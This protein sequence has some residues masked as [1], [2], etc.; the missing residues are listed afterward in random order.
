MNKKK[1]AGLIAAGAVVVA[2]FFVATQNEPLPVITRTRPPPSPSASVPPSG[3]GGT[4][5]YIGCSNTKI[6]VEGYHEVGGTKFWPSLN[7][8]G[9]TIIRWAGDISGSGTYWD[10]FQ[11]QLGK[12]G[13]TSVWWQ[14]CT[15]SSTTPA[16]NATAAAAVLKEIHKRVPNVP[17]YT[18]AINGFSDHVCTLTGAKGPS[19]MQTL[20]TSLTPPEQDGPDVG[21]LSLQ[22]TRPDGCHPNDV[23]SVLIGQILKDFFG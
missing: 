20:A 10:T 15:Q 17:V 21:D 4:I 5:A 7:Y 11:S 6:V 23:G 3:S 18:S 1:V 14:M 8:G 12:S 22:Q 16:A 9:G 19:D 13:A 2:G